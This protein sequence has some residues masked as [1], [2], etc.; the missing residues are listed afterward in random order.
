MGSLLSIGGGSVIVEFPNEA[1]TGADMQWDFVNRDAG[2]FFRLLIQAKRIYGSGS[3]WTRHS[4]KKLLYQTSGKLQSKILCDRARLEAATYP[5]YMFY[6]AE[7]TCT[8]ARSA[9]ISLIEGVNLTDGYLIEQLT[10]AASSSSRA[11]LRLGNLHRYFFN[12][13]DLFCPSNIFPLPIMNFYSEDG[14]QIPMALSFSQG[15]PTLGIPFPPRPEDIRTRLLQYKARVAQEIPPNVSIQGDENPDWTQIPSIM[16][17]I[18]QDV[19]EAM[20]RRGRV[21]T[22]SRHKRYSR[23]RITF[24]SRENKKPDSLEG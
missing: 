21:T 20:E 24:L 23:W 3:Q 5:L 1:S 10:L 17:S 6:N 8:L 11:S 4:Y 9:G 19:M 7:K 15:R 13:R 2:T 22:E 18:P 16:N 14:A 12:L